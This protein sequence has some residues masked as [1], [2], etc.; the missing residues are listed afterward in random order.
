[1]TGMRRRAMATLMLPG[2]TMPLGAQEPE[3]ITAGVA[4]PPGAY[5]PG[6]D[7]VHYEVEV[8]LGYGVLWFEGIT[9]VTVAVFRSNPVLPLDFTGLGI[10]AVT[11]DGASATYTHED[12]ILKLPLEG[13]ARGDTVVVRVHYEGVPDDGLIIRAGS[14]TTV[15]DL[16]ALAAR[17]RASEGL[18]SRSA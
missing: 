18:M 16:T 17:A 6:V 14:E 9:E 4:P 3:P 2:L 11:V 5:A 12:G 8:G 7:A 13:R 1:M 10:N 15:P